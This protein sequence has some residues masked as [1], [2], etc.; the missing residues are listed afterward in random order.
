MV[1]QFKM[2][3]ISHVSSFIS[4]Q[5]SPNPATVSKM[6]LSF[7]QSHC[8]H[9][10]PGPQNL[11]LD[12]RSVTSAGLFDLSLFPLQSTLATT[13]GHSSYL[14]VTHHVQT[15]LNNQ[16]LL[17]RANFIS[18]SFLTQ[19]CPFP[20]DTWV[21]SVVLAYNTFV[22]TSFCS[23]CFSELESQNSSRDWSEITARG[24]GGE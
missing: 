21:S 6:N 5:K 2:V 10:G 13:V 22:Y 18:Y 8:Y 14:P 11:H 15:L 4:N 9:S 1:D 7:L 20:L 19:I 3:L 23:S 12:Q 24:W 17:Q 16:A